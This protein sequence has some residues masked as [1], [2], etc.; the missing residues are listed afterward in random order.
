MLSKTDKLN[1]YANH[2][3][4]ELSKANKALGEKKADEK[5][6]KATIQDQSEM[7]QKLYTKVR[8]ISVKWFANTMV[9]KL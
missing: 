4:S 6:L 9:G 3:E 2:L 8:G 5:S 7:N 1:M